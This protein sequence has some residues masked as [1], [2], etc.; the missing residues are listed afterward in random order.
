MS[1]WDVYICVILL[2]RKREIYYKNEKKTAYIKTF[3]YKLHLILFFSLVG[4]KRLAHWRSSLIY[5]EKHLHICKICAHAVNKV[6]KTAN[7]WGSAL[8]TDITFILGVC[9]LQKYPGNSAEFLFPPYFP[10]SASFSSI[11]ILRYGPDKFNTL[12]C[13]F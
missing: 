13:S 1:S 10:P 3:H 9:F 2:K 8:P 12:K 6:K 4:K 7:C 11:R 5:L